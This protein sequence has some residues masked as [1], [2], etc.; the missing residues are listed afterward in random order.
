MEAVAKFVDEFAELAAK[1]N[2]FPEQVYN[3]DEPVLFWHCIS[4]KSLVQDIEVAPIGDK[5][6]K[7]SVAVLSCWNTAG[8]HKIKLMVIGKSVNP[9][10]FK[11]VKILPFIYYGNKSS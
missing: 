9:R 2:L 3:T 11:G 10:A 6:S 5:D 4:W 1:E 7:D 8:I